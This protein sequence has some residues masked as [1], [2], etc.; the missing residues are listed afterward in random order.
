M[1]H[2]MYTRYLFLKVN[3]NKLILFITIHLWQYDKPILGP[4]NQYN[5]CR[6][7]MLREVK[8]FEQVPFDGTICKLLLVLSL[9]NMDGWIILW[10]W[11]TLQAWMLNLSHRVRM[12]EELKVFGAG[13]FWWPY[14]RYLFRSPEF[15]QVTYCYPYSSVVRRALTILHL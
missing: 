8:V 10:Y 7:Q 9:L 2:H 11:C 14:P 1:Y 13:A 4:H 6:F 5:R 3:A 15:T 12:L